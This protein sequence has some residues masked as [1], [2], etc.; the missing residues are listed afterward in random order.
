MIAS[1]RFAGEY[2]PSLVVSVAAIAAV[3]VAW[4]YIRETKVLDNAY[5]YILP[6]L[7]GTAVALVI[8]ILAGPIWHTKKVVG[9]LGRVIFAIDTS[10][11]MSAT[12]SGQSESSPERLARAS[13]V[14]LGDANNEGWLETLKSTHDVDVLA[15]SKGEPSLIWSSRSDQSLPATLNLDAEG[16]NSDLS[17]AMQ[18]VLSSGTP[19]DQ[20]PEPES[21]DSGKAALV[22]MSDGRHNSGRSPFDFAKQL[23]AAS[24]T[25]HTMGFGSEDEPPDVGIVNIVRPESVASDGQLGGEILLKQFGMSGKPIRIRIESAGKTV[26]EKTIAF[27]TDGQQSV[28]FQLDVEP[29]VQAIRDEAP[30]GVQRRSVV[31][32]LRAAIEPLV[33]DRSDQNNA[34]P[35]RVAASTRDRRLLVMDGSSRWET[36]YLRNL[37]DRDPAWQVDTILFGPGTDMPQLLRG[38]DPGRFPTKRE[39]LGKYDAII[40]GEIPSDQLRAD[41]IVRMREFVARGGGLIVIDGRLGSLRPLVSEQLAD[42]IPVKYIPGQHYLTNVS[43]FQPTQMGLDHPAM[44]LIGNED[45]LTDFWEAIPIP[46][47]VARVKAQEG[48]EVWANVLTDDKQTMPWLVTRMFGSGRVYYFAADQ[49]W[50]WRYKVAD[51]FHAIFWNQV[52]TAVMQPPYSAN[53][54]FVAIG[55]DKTEYEQGQSSVIRARLQDPSGKPVGD[56]TV[57]ALL[58]SN[59][60][61]VATVPLAPE[62]PAR[63]TYQGITP[64]LAAGQYSVRIRASG[65]DESALQ[66]STPIWVGSNPS[67]EMRRVS[68]DRNGLEQIANA[69]DGRYVHESAADELLQEIKPLS[70]GTIVESDTLLWQSYYWFWA[71]VALLATEWWLRKRAGLV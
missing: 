2:P 40:L 21:A 6:A 10:Q 17:S 64:P 56:A 50:R 16:R 57:D 42:V 27:N 68:L 37:F 36:R 26:W 52:M 51:K 39:A 20:Q 23:K 25:V 48:A 28:P 15:F 41:E 19:V 67:S 18:Y 43:R 8:L 70:S 4:L 3:L 62:D 58:V 9:T 53:D 47:F 55:T 22:M 34:M 59:D 30:R 29:I 33:G 5:A 44:N 24:T 66:A 32:D 38:D 69:G 13:Q 46:K 60:R 54:E 31:M 1:L 49:S 12:D 11:S 45:E 7:R 71:V 65:F 63:G 61:I 35:F 14:L